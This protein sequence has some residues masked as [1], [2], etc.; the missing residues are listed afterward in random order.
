MPN[1]VRSIIKSM[2]AKRDMIPDE[3]TGTTFH[4][5]LTKVT[6]H[7]KSPCMTN[8]TITTVRQLVEAFGGRTKFAKFLKVVPT[9]V[10]NMVTDDH[11]PRGY[12]LE[13]YLECQRLGFVIDRRQLF[14]MSERPLARKRVE[15]RA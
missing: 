3:S 4:G 7:D 8:G 1:L 2:K 9:A 14:K 10:S 6:R 15:M 12:H 5:R 11:I 13:I